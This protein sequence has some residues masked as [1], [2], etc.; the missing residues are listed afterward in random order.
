MANPGGI[1][2]KA[3]CW[4][5]S[6]GMSGLGREE[7][8]RG[9]TF[10]SNDVGCGCRRSHDPGFENTD[11][12][13]WDPRSENPDLGTHLRGRPR[14]GP[15]ADRTIAGPLNTNSESFRPDHSV[16]VVV[17]IPVVI[18]HRT[19]VVLVDFSADGQ[20]QHRACVLVGPEM[21]AAINTSVADVV[22]DLLERG[23]LQ[24]DGRHGGV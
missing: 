9:L 18:V 15:P 16:I 14:Y 2:C 7:A 4:N 3:G 12:G 22:G 21:D 23:V 8:I 24:D 17:I 11:P 13:R 20:S 5:L 1:T 10:L 6:N 19:Q